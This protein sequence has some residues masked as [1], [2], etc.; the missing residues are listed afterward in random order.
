MSSIIARH[1]AVSAIVWHTF[2]ALRDNPR[3]DV[4]LFAARN[5][6]VELPA[7]VVTAVT[8]ALEQIS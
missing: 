5:D 7:N 1:D 6:F 3:F 8:K 2:E 4:S